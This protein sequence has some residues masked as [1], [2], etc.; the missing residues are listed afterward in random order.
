MSDFQN[1]NLVRK[2]NHWK[3]C[4]GTILALFTFGASFAQGTEVLFVERKKD[5]SAKNQNHFRQM[6]I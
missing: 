4:I 3:T 2:K 5:M 6:R 1:K